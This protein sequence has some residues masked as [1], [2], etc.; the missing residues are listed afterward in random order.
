M[1]K[2]ICYVFFFLMIRRPPRSTLFPYPTLF[3][4][5]RDVCRSLLQTLKEMNSEE[6]GKPDDVIDREELRQ[7][8][9]HAMVSSKAEV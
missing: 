4:S 2:K 1:Y 7:A 9:M 5:V 3:R 6:L 8:M